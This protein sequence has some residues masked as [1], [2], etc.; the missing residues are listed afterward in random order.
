M[1][2]R[3][4]KNDTPET[5]TTASV[6]EQIEP[7]I[8]M[9]GLGQVIEEDIQ[10]W[11]DEARLAEEKMAG[12][13]AKL[14]MEQIKTLP[15]SWAAMTPNQQSD[16]YSV[17]AAGCASLA[18][19]AIELMASRGRRIIKGVMKQVTIK[20]EIQMTITCQRSPEACVAMGMASAG[21][22]VAFLLLHTEGFLQLG[23][24]METGPIQGELDL[25]GTDCPLPEELPVSM[26]HSEV[27]HDEEC[28]L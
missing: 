21:G 4:S 8:P 7:D 26:P 11:D 25:D 17:V 6:L 16:V 15:R 27:L 13:M 18:S 9:M 20:D 28:L 3:K 14:L 22:E 5:D 23:S 1:A 24:P 19:Q 2:R 12:D 10:P